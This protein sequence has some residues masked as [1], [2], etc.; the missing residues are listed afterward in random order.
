MPLVW[1]GMGVAEVPAWPLCGA[2][3]IHAMAEG[4]TEFSSK[5]AHAPGCHTKKATGAASDH[6]LQSSQPPLPSPPLSGSQER[7]VAGG[8]SLSAPGPLAWAGT[9]E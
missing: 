6:R 5:P 7:A 9:W 3:F 1:M 8:H 4:Q 2:G